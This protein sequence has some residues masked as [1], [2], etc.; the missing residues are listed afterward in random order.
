MSNFFLDGP[1]SSCPAHTVAAADAHFTKVVALPT[2]A[3][4][5]GN[6]SL[7]EITANAQL[8]LVMELT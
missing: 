1:V 4:E 3:A 2:P 7:N 8:G 5:S 6:V